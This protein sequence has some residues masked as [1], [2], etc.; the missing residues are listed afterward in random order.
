M[1]EQQ[2]IDLFTKCRTMIDSNSAEGINKLRDRAF[3]AFRELGFPTKQME[4]FLHSDIAG[5]FAPDYGLN[6]QRIEYKINPYKSFGCNVP[7]M[8]T[9][10][11]FVLNDSF[12]GKHLPEVYYPEGV[13]VG[14]LKDFAEQHPDVFSKYYGN[15]MEWDKNGV[16]AFNTM[17]VQDGFVVYI[18]DNTVLEQPL[19]L[20]NILKS[21]VNFLVNRRIMLIAG[22]NSQVK[23]LVCDHAVDSANFLVTQVTEI[24]AGENSHVDFY[25][26]EENSDNVT[27]LAATFI[28]QSEGSNVLSNNLTLNCGF[29]RNNY[30]VKLDGEHAET[31]VAGMIIAGKKQHVDNFAFLDHAKP[32]CQSTQ[33]FK[34]V[35]QDSALGAFCGRILVEKDA[36]KTQAYQTNNNLCTTP[37]SRMYS[38]PQLEIYADDV[39]CSHGLTT[40]QLDEEALLYMR[41]RGIGKDTARLML[42]QAFTA[43]VLKLIRLDV[44]KDRLQ[45]LVEKRFKGETARCGNC[46]IC[47]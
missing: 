3:D 13:F 10:L 2:Y 1:I 37:D 38:K 12:Q 23:L 8:S 6:L 33:L 27:R 11:Y 30:H 41:A 9:N 46:S 5:K 43:D 45:D 31:T 17:F 39:K 4:D 15:A 22:K 44:L 7:E 19:Q 25:E 35:L 24:F 28:H 40:G 21:S 36:Q 34:Y 14:G 20:V 26:L 16:N 47:K 42:M 18:P 29:T 32:N